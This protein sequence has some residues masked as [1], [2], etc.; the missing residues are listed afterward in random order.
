MNYLT[1]GIICGLAFG[2]LDVL[3]MIPLKYEDSRKKTEAMTAAFIE[4]FMIGF[5]IPVTG[6]NIDPMITGLIIG[7]GLSIPSAIITRV[8][9]P[10]IVIGGAGGF[11][12][13]LLTKFYFNF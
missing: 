4:R 11:I 7:L 5:L 8:Y 2:I 10:I 9:V 3:I 1:F 13:G 12:I 6:L